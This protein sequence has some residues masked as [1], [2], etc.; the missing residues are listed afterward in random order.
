MK[1]IIAFVIVC[2]MCGC[3]QDAYDKGEGEYSLLRGDFVEAQVNTSKQVVSIMTDDGDLLSL[4]EPYS[5]KWIAKADTFYRC[6]LYYNKVEDHHGSTIADVISMWQV[7][8][9]RVMPLNEFDKEIKT[10]PVK[11]ESMWVSR[12]G[13]YLNMSLMLKTG[14]TDDS[15]AVHQLAVVCDTVISKSMFLRLHHDQGGVP[16]YYSTNA[17]IS[18]PTSQLPADTITITLNTYDGLVQKQFVLK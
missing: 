10:D 16:E 2:L 7:P 6:M 5:A 1:Q 4:A 17:Y 3:T 14:S 18:I 11:F 12:S 15:T 13:K 8:C 9:P